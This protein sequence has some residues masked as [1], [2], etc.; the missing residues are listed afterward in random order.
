MMCQKQT[1]RMEPINP[2][3]TET[4]NAFIQ[5]GKT[6]GTR[7]SRPPTKDNYCLKHQGVK[8]RDDLKAAGNILCSN[9]YRGCCSTIS[10]ENSEKGIKT[11]AEC[12]EKK[13]L[14]KFSCKHE[15]C[16]YGVMEEGKYCK[17]HIG[18]ELREH[19]KDNKIRY[20]KINRGCRNELKEGEIECNDCKNKL[21]DNIVPIQKENNIIVDYTPFSLEL[22]EY[23]EFSVSTIEESWRYFQRRA[24]GDK[25]L[26]NIDFNE[27]KKIIIKPCYY[28]GFHS[29]IKINGIDRVNNTKGYITPNILSCCAVCNKIKHTSH[30]L[31]FLDKV[32]AIT[33]YQKEKKSLSNQLT[34]KWQMI[35]CSAKNA[36]Y[37]TYKNEQEN[38]RNI[39]FK[40]TKDEY[41]ELKKQPCYLCGIESNEINMNGID[42]VNSNL[43][44]YNNENCRACCGHCNYMKN[45]LNLSHFLSKCYEINLYKCNR[46]IF[47]LMDILVQK[48]NAARNEDYNPDDIYDFI[49]NKKINI[50]GDW[51]K[52]HNK[53]DEYIVNI[54]DLNN[55]PGYSKEQII[56]Y[57]TDEINLEKTRKIEITAYITANNLYNMLLLNKKEEFIKWME[58]NKGISLQFYERLEDLIKELV[59]KNK[60]E[61]V[62]LCQKFMYAEKNRRNTQTSR[63][64]IE[65]V[66]PQ[67]KEEEPVQRKITI[68]DDLKRIKRTAIEIPKQ[69][70][71]TNIYEFIKEGNEEHYISWCKEN[72]E[73]DDAS[74]NMFI[75]N[76]KENITNYDFCK[77]HTEKF[78]VE[79]RTARTLKLLEA[80]KKDVVERDD[81]QQWPSTTVLKAYK[82]GKI[83]TFKKFTEEYAGD[84][85]EKWEKR[86]TEFEDSLADKTDEEATKLISKFMTAQ[87]TK[88]YRHSKI[89]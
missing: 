19:A 18:T 11:C 68:I 37:L 29:Q 78:I 75:A 47:N 20:C 31:A 67:K 54:L 5:E 42:R 83:A 77:E 28:C 8:V 41:Y 55:H 48:K 36:S 27:Y 2:S 80:T 56:Q 33:K 1:L 62:Q 43:R 6:K 46:T 84:S 73:I 40:L 85:G 10:K 25:I 32:D 4:C 63:H 64:K 16:P 81:R 53:S 72:N 66:I 69:W 61:G 82:E 22:K 12:S 87:R 74:I 50:Y 70:K 21:K 52:E 71:V 60:K 38:E 59:E 86:W 14:K 17:K 45:T 58:E 23:Q 26:V 39:I 7:C 3:T 89:K 13:K 76:I 65:K 15:G 44:I 9:D 57:I 34:C 30:P 35:Y 88:K 79:L 24:Y 51:C 49:K